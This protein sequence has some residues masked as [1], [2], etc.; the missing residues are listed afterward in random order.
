MSET[1]VLAYSGGL[2]TT[3]CLHWLQQK[4]YK[5]ITLLAQ[6]GQHQYL[7]PDGEKALN[8]GAADVHIID[9]RQRFIKDYIWPTL[10][11]NAKY[12]S[13][14][15]LSSA[16]TR[17]LIA[18]ELIRIANDEN[19]S[20]VA[21]GARGIGNEHIRFEN[22]ILTLDPARL[23]GGPK[24][25]IIAPLKELGLNSVK[26]DVDYARN[27]H[28]PLERI[29]Y[30]LYNMEENL[31]GLNIHL[32]SITDVQTVKK[33]PKWETPSDTYIITTPIMETSDTPII[34]EITFR[35][36]EPTQLD[37]K[38]MNSLELINLLNRIGG[39]TAIGRWEMIEHKISGE[40][41]LEVYEAPAATILYKAHQALEEIAL[42]KELLHYKNSLSQKY[43][44][45]VYDGFW[46]SPLRHALDKFFEYTQQSVTGSVKMKL[47]KGNMTVIG[48][49]LSATADTQKA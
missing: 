34:L 5:V 10:K 24:I 31:W 29:K 22:S 43:G 35:K 47:L 8:V 40:K 1:V 12:E 46:F 2:D 33:E 4:G 3:I 25:K 26:D 30:T 38:K 17:P 42:D 32:G 19:C 36:G 16:L 20:F 37:A 28:L 45:L 6:L 18:E 39:R 23:A 44:E 14:Y 21:H 27:N 15:L 49:K 9:L 48:R 41:T 13:G 7:E 11:A